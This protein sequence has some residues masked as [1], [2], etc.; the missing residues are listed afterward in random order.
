MEET[1][2]NGS[3]LNSDSKLGNFT[4]LPDIGMIISVFE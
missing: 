4:F 2:T 3:I 1:T